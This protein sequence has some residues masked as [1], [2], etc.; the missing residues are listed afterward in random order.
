MK[1]RHLTIH[2][3]AMPMCEQI[4][5]EQEA[6]AAR[7]E[8]LEA[9]FATKSNFVPDLTESAA[10]L[11]VTLLGISVGTATTQAAQNVAINSI[12]RCLVSHGMMKAA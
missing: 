10:A 3:N 8:T 1:L 4:V 5:F 7:M 2:D 9:H 12:K 6:Q 11:G